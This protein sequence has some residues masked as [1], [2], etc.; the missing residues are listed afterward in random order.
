MKTIEI[1][2]SDYLDESEIKEIVIEEYRSALRNK[3]SNEK[4]ITRIIGNTW[5]QEF[6]SMLDEIVPN[7]K[8]IIIDNVA[9]LINEGVNGYGVFRAKN[10]WNEA[11]IAT[12]IVEETVNANRDIL[13]EKVKEAMITK[14]FSRE[15]LDQLGCVI[16]EMYNYNNDTIGKIHSIFCDLKGE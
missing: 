6:H 2:I 9:K 15:I 12:K 10:H 1:N 5:Y 7:Y 13:K 16:D 8:Q 4:E 11:S 14:D 3:L